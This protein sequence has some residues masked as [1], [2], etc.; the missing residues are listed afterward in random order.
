MQTD[1]RLF[2]LGSLAALTRT[3]AA[4]PGW[5][6]PV[7]PTGRTLVLLQ[8]TGGHDGLS[9]L[10]PY[11]DDGYA[12][13]RKATRLGADEVL[14]LD[15]RVGLHPAL[16]GL[17]ALHEE[18]RLALVE[19][20]GYPE[21]DRSHFRSLDIWHAADPR[22]RG[23]PAGWIGR[24]VERLGDAHPHAVVHFGPRP[25][26]ALHA[27]R[28]APVCLTPLVLRAAT[29]EEQ[30]AAATDESAAVARLRARMRTTEDALG[31]IRA[32]LDGA[33]PQ[34]YPASGLATRLRQAAALIHAGLG[35][36]VVSLE[37][38][39]FDTHRDQRGRHDRLMEELDRALTAFAADLARSEAGRATLVLGY[40]EFGRRVAENDSGGTDHGA[41]G[42]AFALGSSVRGGLHGAPPDLAR[43]VDGDLAFTTDFR[44][45][46]APA[47]EHVF[48]LDAAEILGR[49]FG[50]LD[51]V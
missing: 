36:R 30:D 3:S 43:L 27:A 41:A 24:C 45:F 50:G 10:V 16:R 37:L 33:E 18:G 15:E 39:G 38:D 49:D 22:G 11:A 19:G 46:Y 14:R 51:Y 23:M 44:A 28:R 8:L 29:L 17:R 48:G 5:A 47:I 7:E 26:F 4:C 9:M 6:R 21:P 13:A 31:G 40:S 2:L 25:P 35:V 34:P 20:I 42:L 12:S 32:A 1:R